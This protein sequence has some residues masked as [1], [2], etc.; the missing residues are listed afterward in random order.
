MTSVKIVVVGDGV[1][2]KTCLLMYVIISFIIYPELHHFVFATRFLI[3]STT[4]TTTPLL[5]LC[6][7]VH[8]YT[9]IHSI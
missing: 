9:I 5:L 6:Y 3:L 1:V 8:F 4:T 2:G 7:L